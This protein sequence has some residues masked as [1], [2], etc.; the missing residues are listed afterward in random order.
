MGTVSVTLEQR[1]SDNYYEL[2]DQTLYKDVNEFLEQHPDPEKTPLNGTIGLKMITKVV[3]RG[4]RKQELQGYT[5]TEYTP[6]VLTAALAYATEAIKR[7]EEGTAKQ[8]DFDQTERSVQ[9][10]RGHLY[11]NAAKFQW[12]LAKKTE[13]NEQQLMTARDHYTDSIRICATY[14]PSMEAYTCQAK[15]ELELE[16]AL[17][18]GNPSWFQEAMDD[19]E[20]ASEKLEK[21]DF[22]EAL[23][24]RQ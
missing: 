15:A 16:L 17:K 2:T 4:L 3:S 9:I 22:T 21:Y 18:T 6:K 5:G 24:C 13:H 11:R 14:D 19:Y 23:Q 8:E 1:L 20:N 7:I 12:E 10:M